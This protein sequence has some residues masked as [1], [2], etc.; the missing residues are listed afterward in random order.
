[1]IAFSVYAKSQSEDIVIIPDTSLRFRVIANSNSL[2]DYLIKTKVKEHVEEE[3][4]KLLSSAKTLQETKDILKENINN[5]NNV[6]RDSLEE[7]EDFQINLGLNYFPKKVYKGVVYPEGYY[8][9]LVITIG[10]GN[11][12]NW[13]CVLFPPLCLLEQNDNTEDVEY[14]FFISRIIKYFK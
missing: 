11:G 1:M 13:W 6:V 5:I 14:R 10:E 9:S 2:D 8:D 7:K 4:I 12:E 3:L